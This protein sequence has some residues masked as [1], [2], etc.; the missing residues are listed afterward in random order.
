[1]TWVQCDISTNANVLSG[2]FVDVGDNYSI[3]ELNS[4][5][6]VYEEIDAENP[7]SEDASH[8]SDTM[9]YCI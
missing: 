5:N 7:N 3:I 4:N 9:S 2:L 6:F 1:M 8:V